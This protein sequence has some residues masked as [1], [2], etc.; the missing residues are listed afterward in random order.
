MSDKLQETTKKDNMILL[1]N[2]KTIFM[3]TPKLRDVRAVKHIVDIEDREVA[4]ISNLTGLSED[5]LDDLDY[6]DYSLLDER[7]A[8]FLLPVGKNILRA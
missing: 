5:E 2:D 4:L 1:S 6:Q 3:R 8:A 7:L